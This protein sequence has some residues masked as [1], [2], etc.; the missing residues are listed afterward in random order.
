[1]SQ[2]ISKNVKPIFLNT[3]YIFIFNIR[4]VFRIWVTL[5]CIWISLKQKYGS[6]SS[7]SQKNINLFKVLV[8]IWKLQF[9]IELW[10]FFLFFIINSPLYSGSVSG[11]GTYPDPTWSNYPD[12][13]HCLY[14]CISVY[15]YICIFVYLYIC[16]SVYLYICISVYLY[17]CIFPSKQ[18]L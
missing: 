12:P 9:M 13:K 7:F 18:I 6:G 15:L 2:D 4:I 11:S 14:I 8:T 16:I 10:G 3:L 1:M 5:S 17:V